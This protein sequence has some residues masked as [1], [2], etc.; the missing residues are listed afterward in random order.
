MEASAPNLKAV[1]KFMDPIICIVGAFVILAILKFAWRNRRLRPPEE[2]F[3]FVYVN[4]DGSARELTDRE[5]EYLETDF[6]VGDGNRPYVKSTY[7]TRDGWGSISG[8]VDRRKVPPAVL[9]SM[10]SVVIPPDDDDFMAD[11]IADA[12]AAGDI[13]ER[14]S[15]GSIGVIPNPRISSRRRFRIYAERHL[16]R[17]KRREDA[18]MTLIV[19]EGAGNKRSAGT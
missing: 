7:K 15:D 6:E 19:T 3:R 16:R 11:I 18:V 17:Q 2:G 1:R 10:V 4:Q 14:G 12:E 5:R 9:I 8:Y 13:I